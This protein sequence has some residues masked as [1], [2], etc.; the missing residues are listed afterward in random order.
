[1]PKCIVVSNDG[2]YL[3]H[4]K[5]TGVLHVNN[6][7]WVPDPLDAALFN[8]EVKANK[9]VRQSKKKPC[10]VVQIEMRV[11]RFNR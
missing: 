8:T 11:R 9:A 6:T 1:M 10:D 7:V 4:R 2:Y 3:A 5:D